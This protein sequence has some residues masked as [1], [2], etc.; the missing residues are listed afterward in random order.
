MKQL[1]KPYNI[2]QMALVATCSAVCFSTFSGT[3]KLPVNAC[4]FTHD[5]ALTKDDRTAIAQCL[6]WQPT[7][8]PSICKGSYQ[9]YPMTPLNSKDEV[10]VSADNVSLMAE[11]QSALHGHVDVQ[12]SQRIVNAQTAYIYRDAHTGDITKIELLGDVRYREP[13]RL[14]I[15]N[16]ATIDPRTKAGQIEDLIYRFDTHKSNSPLPAWGHARWAERFANEDYLLK[17]ATYTT[18]APQDKAWQIDAKE[19]T[20]DHAKATGR[21]K[22]AVLRVAGMPVFYAPYLTFPTT[23]ARKSGFLTPLVGYSNVGG[24]DLALPY[25][26]NIA[27]NYDA[28]IT[29]HVYTL[30]GLM[31]GGEFRVLTQKS[32]GIVSANILPNDQAFKYFINQ[33][34]DMSP[35]LKGASTDRW[36]VLVNEHTQ[37]NDNLQTNI[38]FRQVSDD[39]YLQDFSNNLGVATENQLP[40]EADVSYLTDHWLFRGMVQDY[41]TLHPINQ[42]AVLSIYQRLPQLLAH[43]SYHELPLHANLD[44]LSQY[45]NFRWPDNTPMQ[46]QGPR[47]H[48]SPTLSFPF[49][50]SWGHVTPALALEENYYDVQYMGNN[51]STSFNRTIPEYSVDSGL[52]F[53]RSTAIRGRPYTQLLEPRLYYLN[54]AYHD[55][56][57][58]PVYDSAYMIFTT[59]Q[60]F[61]NNRFSGFDRI[62]DTN[63]LA[64]AL[65]SRWLSDDSGLEKASFTVGQIR[66][67]QNR[68]VLL[69]YQQEGPCEENPLT[70]GYLSPTAEA[71]PIASRATYQ[72][73]PNWL[74]SGDYVWDPNTHA[75][76]NGNLNLHYQPSMNH[77]L[78]VGYTYMVSGNVLQMPVVGIQNKPLHQA[79]VGYAMPFNEQWSGIGAY[80]HNVSDNYSMMSLLGVQYD[81]CCWAMRFMGGRSFQ[82]I[83][84]ST[85]NPQYNNNVYFQVLLKGLGSVG[86][87]NPASLINTYLPG[88]KSLF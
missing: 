27:P 45:D 67:F 72:L 20:L 8:S 2:I 7:D 83:A 51:P 49:A 12:D 63:Q 58:V 53:E 24:F 56:T 86:T 80:S 82:S 30:R 23:N 10:R 13:D 85:F 65:T 19:I 47:Y 61:R 37:F 38:N 57:P 66:Y 43:A 79:T 21:A 39:Y 71:S 16:K 14:M 48:W 32:T 9:S 29:P 25:Y 87:S 11:G 64:Y 60:L 31:M 52:S 18:C 78:S 15:A 1:I 50:R 54:I 3:H 6:G 26:W 28:T 73:N 40:R 76:N 41:Q 70:L 68:R 55:Q 62:G 88:Y 4:I 46:P 75:T 42:S 35:S 81:T 22:H 59:D 34:Q 17:K 33:N 44:M 69:C 84:P 77:V 5:H 36:T 74:A